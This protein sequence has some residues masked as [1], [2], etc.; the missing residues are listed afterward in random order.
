[1]YHDGTVSA[2]GS[3]VAWLPFARHRRIAPA[4]TP[5]YFGNSEEEAQHWLVLDRER[6]TLSVGAVVDVQPFL[7][8]S[9][10]H[11]CA[12]SPAATV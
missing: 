10:P 3:W 4:L 1:V 12:A 9:A 2:D 6:R 5:Y 11:V 7:R 8:H